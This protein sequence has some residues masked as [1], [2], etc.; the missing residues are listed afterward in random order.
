MK[1]VVNSAK[2]QA[3]DDYTINHIG[4]PGMVLMEKAAN[5]VV[6]EMLPVICRKDRILAVCGTGNNGGD[7]VAAARILKEQGYQVDIHI[8]GD[9][10]RASEQTKHQLTIA[11]NLNVRIDSNLKI[12]EYNVI[13]DAIFGIGLSKPVDGAFEQ[14]IKSINSS[15]NN[16]VF[17]VDVPSGIHA[18]DG[19][20]MNIAVKADYTITFGLN[21]IGLILYP[22]CD[23]AGK[24]TVAEIGFPQKAIEYVKPATFIYEE[25]D[26][27]KLPY[28][29]NDSNKGTFG[30]V[31]IIAGSKNMSGAC[32]LS[33]KAAYRTGAGL[34][35]ILTVEDNRSILQTLLPEA[36][37]ATYD[38][39]SLKNKLEVDRILKELNWATS[40]VL[41]PGIGISG[42]S[43]H[44]LDIVLSHT[45]APIVI[46]ADALTMLAGK[47]RYVT[48][49]ME[50]EVYCDID[51]P[52]NVIITPHLKE[53]A[54]MLDC[55]V[56]NVK[57][58]LLTV[59]TNVVKGKRFVLAL[60]DTRTMVSDGVHCF[61]NNV[62]NNGMAT[63]GS[64]DVLTGIIAAMIAQGMDRFE[65]TA[66]SV[67]VHGLAGDK[68]LQSKSIYSLMASDIIEA[69]PLVLRGDN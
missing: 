46:D 20:V 56:S 58:N 17:S 67:Y 15:E 37:L 2:M 25:S 45:E 39:S 60:K 28:R 57:E 55:E 43:D 33:A 5:A 41:G 12:C 48:K 62:G 3:I 1:Y 13:I 18:D 19:K 69:L 10:K 35:K 4:I 54:R 42:A 6:T 11:R 26:L 36:I 38:P 21:K 66:L 34:V 49:E 44:L 14:A 59:A 8:I 30:K 24:V 61:I 63:G 31:L 50:K 22:G 65:A 29:K 27:S 52:A 40:I 16:I 32:Y 68:A 47:T 23:Y 51:L 7:G 9:E 64:G 53:M